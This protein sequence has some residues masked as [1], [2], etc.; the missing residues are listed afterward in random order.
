[1]SYSLQPNELKPARLLCQWNSPG[2]N[3]GVSCHSLPRGIFLTPG[4]EPQTPALQADSLQSGP[5]E[6][7]KAIIG[8]WHFPRGEEPRCVSRGCC[9]WAQGSNRQ[10]TLGSHSQVVRVEVPWALLLPTIN[11][12]D[13]NQGFSDSSVPRRISP[14]C[15]SDSGHMRWG[16][17]ACTSKEL[18]RKAS[19]GGPGTTLWRARV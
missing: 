5:S 19:A 9:P 1:M 4:M 8:R 18:S 13:P 14:K 12:S 15:K 2:K 3:T 10:G 6:K 16:L 7:P 17:R 11:H